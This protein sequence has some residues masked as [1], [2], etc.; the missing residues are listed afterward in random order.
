V[1][2][3]ASKFA[4]AL[5]VC[6]HNPEG[7]SSPEAAL[8]NDRRFIQTSSS[9]SGTPEWLETTTLR[10]RE[11]HREPP[12]VISDTFQSGGHVA[13]TWT[14]APP[15]KNSISRWPSSWQFCARQSLYEIGCVAVFTGGEFTDASPRVHAYAIGDMSLFSF[16]EIWLQQ[17]MDHAFS[18]DHSYDPT[19]RAYAA[20]TNSSELPAT[21]GDRYRRGPCI[22]N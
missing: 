6:A 13:P 8:R 4:G 21:Q 5:G 17:T 2:P 18:T 14:A 10:K 3:S 19:H 7:T 22:G 12:S 16:N 15:E 20:E 11:V 9:K 1:P